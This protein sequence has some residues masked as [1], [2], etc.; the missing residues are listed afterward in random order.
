MSDKRE[1]DNERSELPRADAA[2]SPTETRTTI[3]HKGQLCEFYADWRGQKVHFL[4]AITTTLPE[5]VKSFDREHAGEMMEVIIF[6][7]PVPNTRH[8][9]ARK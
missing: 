1:Q 4:S 2:A 8:E 9:P 3:Q 6:A 5:T 7:R